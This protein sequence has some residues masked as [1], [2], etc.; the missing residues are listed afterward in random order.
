MRDQQQIV[1]ICVIELHLS[2]ALFIGEDLGA[3][4]GVLTT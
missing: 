4:P 2:I 3:K 1:R